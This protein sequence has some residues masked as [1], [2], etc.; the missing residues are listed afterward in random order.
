MS[1]VPMES[2]EEY[3]SV[4]DKDLTAKQ[5][6]FVSKFVETN[7]ATKSA[8][9]VYD[10]NSPNVAGVIGYENLRKPNVKKAIEVKKEEV[11]S[12]IESETM[13][14]V[15]CLLDL[16]KNPSVPEHVRI[17]AITDLLDRADISKQSKHVSIEANMTVT[18]GQQNLANRAR[19]LLS[20]VNK[21][22][23]EGNTADE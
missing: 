19:E 7:N 1:K 20:N 16:A 22:C 11:L 15:C 2:V 18:P 8:L 12:K 23:L 17:K 6:L 9:E 21:T 5:E 14:L 4:E 10:T 3:V 13:N